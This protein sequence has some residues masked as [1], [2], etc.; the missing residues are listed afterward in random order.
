MSEAPLLKAL[1][2]TLPEGQDFT[3]EQR[4]RFFTAL[5]FN[6]D[7]VYGPPSDGGNLDPQGVA[8]LWSVPKN[9]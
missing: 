4:K 9:D 3:T 1:W 8:A 5:A 7:Y 6:I 2:D